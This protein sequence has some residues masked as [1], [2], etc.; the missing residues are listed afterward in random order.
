MIQHCGL[1]FEVPPAAPGLDER[2]LF[3]GDDEMGA[4][5]EVVAVE[6][7]TGGILV[8]HAMELREQYRPHYDEARR[9]RT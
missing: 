9:W 3:L 7:Q 6:L 1:V 2:L 4:A 5:L 8:I